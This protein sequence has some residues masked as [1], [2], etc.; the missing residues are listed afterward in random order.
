MVAKGEII[1]NAM[2]ERVGNSVFTLIQKEFNPLSKNSILSF[3]SFKSSGNS[4]W[5]WS[6][7]SLTLPNGALKGFCTQRNW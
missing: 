3:E 1:N 4:S 6:L 7:R 5:A 2:F